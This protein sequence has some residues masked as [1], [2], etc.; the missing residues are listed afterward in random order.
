MLQG[1]SSPPLALAEALA[2]AGDQAAARA[3][4]RDARARLEARAARLPRSEWRPSFLARPEST[5]ILALAG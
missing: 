5:R 1:E 4:A 3:A 2:A